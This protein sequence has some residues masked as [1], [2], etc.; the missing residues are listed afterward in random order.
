[1]NVNYYI[2][3]KFMAL[4]ELILLHYVIIK[5]RQYFLFKLTQGEYLEVTHRYHGMGQLN[6]KLIILMSLL[7][8]LFKINAL[9]RSNRE[10]NL[11]YTLVQIILLVWV[12]VTISVFT[13]IVT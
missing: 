12:A 9:L 7:F 1:M 11:Q 6:G 10:T 2:E 5:D 13:M 3:L 8:F 4:K